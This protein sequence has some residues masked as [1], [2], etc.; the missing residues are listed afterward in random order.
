MLFFTSTV[1]VPIHTIKQFSMYA[2]GPLDL[3]DNELST[4]DVHINN[5]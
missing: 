2:V 1:I 4:E 3:E 5:L